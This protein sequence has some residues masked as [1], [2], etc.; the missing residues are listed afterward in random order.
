MSR[1]K[2]SRSTAKLHWNEMDRTERKDA[3]QLV[4]GQEGLHI[5]SV[6]SPV[7][8]RKQERAR[9]KCLRALILELHA[10]GVTRLCLEAREKELNARDIHT[11][12]TVRQTALPKGTQIR[13]DHTP[14]ATEP[15]L[16]I[17]D[18]VAGAV[19]AQRQGDSTYTDLLD[20]TLMD[21]DVVT[22]C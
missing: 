11:V 5:V 4:A 17:S 21:F 18:I 19:R 22:D 3:A 16:W 15:L 20:R 6:G 14:G 8:R 13:A 12:A 2:G 9:A 10:F 1:F 7:P